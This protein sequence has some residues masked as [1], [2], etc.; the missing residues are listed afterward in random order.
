[1]NAV[2]VPKVG[3]IGCCGGRCCKGCVEEEALDIVVED[4]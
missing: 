3:D 2:F 1:M 4:A